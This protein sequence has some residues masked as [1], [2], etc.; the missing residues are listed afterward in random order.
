MYNNIVE[1]ENET[2]FSVVIYSIDGRVVDDR[3]NI[4]HYVEELSSG[5]YVLRV[6]DAK[7]KA[8]VVR[9]IIIR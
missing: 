8:S 2:D 5:C 6:K 7:S 1:I 4:R 3:K 9:K